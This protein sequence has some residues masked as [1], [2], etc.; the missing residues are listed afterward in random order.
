VKGIVGKF[1]VRLVVS[2]VE[3]LGVRVLMLG[4]IVPFSHGG[5]F[6]WVFQVAY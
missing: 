6:I 1:G 5:W 4:V 2:T 3:C